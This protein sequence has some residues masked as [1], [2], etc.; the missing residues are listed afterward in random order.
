MQ[1]TGTKF[2]KGSGMREFQ[3]Q[4]F[5]SPIR[6]RSSLKEVAGV[7]SGSA[8]MVQIRKIKTYWLMQNFLF[9]A[10]RIIAQDI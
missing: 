10:Y 5:R 3:I 9:S 1:I 7:Y 8:L 4:S 6:K 2:W